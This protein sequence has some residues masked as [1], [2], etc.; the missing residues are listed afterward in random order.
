LPDPVK[1]SGTAVEASSGKIMPKRH[2]ENFNMKGFKKFQEPPGK[3]FW[4]PDKRR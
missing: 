4:G 1:A 3:I 2:G